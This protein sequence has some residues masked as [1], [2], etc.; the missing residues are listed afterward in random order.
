VT[1]ATSQPLLAIDVPTANATTGQPF[2]V[3]GWAIDLGA[4]SGTGVDAVHVYAVANGGAG[5]QTLLGA[6]T[7]GTARGDVGAAYG[8]PFTN[9]GYGLSV[10]GLAPGSYQINVYA[11]S[12]VSGQWTVQSR[13][14]TVQ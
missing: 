8:S 3:A 2:S 9:S 7:Y 6:A 11:H 4:P 5:A 1:V 10:T 13:L 14:V 12:T